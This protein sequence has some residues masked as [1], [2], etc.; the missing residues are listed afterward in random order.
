MLTRIII[1][2]NIEIKKHIKLADFARGIKPNNLFLIALV[3]SLGLS[4]YI[5]H[6]S[7]GLDYLIDMALGLILCGVVALPVLYEYRQ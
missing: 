7:I 1:S 5:K 3:L 4:H 6:T 2:W